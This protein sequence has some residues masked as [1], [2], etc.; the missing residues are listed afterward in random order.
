MPTSPAHDLHLGSQGR[1]QVTGVPTVGVEEE[2]TLLD[3]RSGMV[4]PAAAEVIRECQHPT[5]VVPESMRFMVETRTPVCTSLTEVHDALSTM[6][7]HVVDVASS[8]GVAIVAS[9]VA[10]FGLPDPPP[11][12]DEP[13]YN[14]LAQAFPM[15]IRAA[16]TCG[17][18]V[19]VG[20]PTREVAVDA[21]L[22]LRPWLPPL[23]ALTANSPIWEGAVTSWASQR[24]RLASR[25]PTLV[26]SP[27]ARSVDEYDLLVDRAVAS[28]KALDRRNVYFLAR[29]SPRYPTIEVRAADM[30]L[31]A[32]EAAAYAGL[33]RALVS[34]AMD[35]AAA[36]RPIVPVQDS[37]LRHACR[38]AARAG[39]RG[40]MIEP[41]T[42]SPVRSWELVDALVRRVRPRLRAHGDEA[43][44]LATIG[45]YRTIGG[46]ADRQRRLLQRSGSRADFVAALAAATTADL[47]VASA[48]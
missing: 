23:I 37:V 14:K 31:T 39:L 2:F 34:G 15:A 17:C 35:D 29:L 20:V 22:R 26:P 21:L 45:R 6:R 9:G 11:V 27:P 47:G 3:P 10:P 5:G 25:W 48:L 1:S 41:W 13:R 28:G 7:R 38:S 33:V 18:H 19:H 8:Y 16:G 43:L 30:S 44:V 4:V 24:L 46:G 12:T 42:G 40:M 32:Q 36:G